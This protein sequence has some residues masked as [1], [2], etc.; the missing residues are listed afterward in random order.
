[1]PLTRGKIKVLDAAYWMKGCRSLG[2]LRCEAIKAAAVKC[3][4]RNV[5]EGAHERSPFLGDRMLAAKFL[6]RDL[7]IRELLPQDL[8]LELDQL[9]RTGATSA[10]QYLAAVIGK[11]QVAD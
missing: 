1:L 4:Q 9:T 11:A 5:V 3:P 7:F 8:K 6:D 10:V 2:R